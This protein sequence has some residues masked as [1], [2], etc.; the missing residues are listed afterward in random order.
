[1]QDVV[2]VGGGVIGLSIA[3]ELALN[4]H[5]V[6]VID[7]AE[8]GREASWA[9]AGILPPGYCGEPDD[10]LVELTAAT[11]KLWPA[12][13]ET[14]RAETGI[15]NGF[16]RSGSI[17]LMPDVSTV[18][19][20][21]HREK[22]TST[23][24]QEIAAWRSVG[25]EVEPLSPKQ[26]ARKEPA[27]SLNQAIGYRLP[28]LCQV[29]NPWHLKAIIKSCSQAGVRLLPH[30]PLRELERKANRITAAVV[31]G[32]RL[33][34]DQFVIAAG[35]WA[36]SLLESFKLLPPPDATGSGIPHIQPVRGQIVLLKLKKPPFRHV[37]ECGHRYLVPRDDG[38]VLIGATEE[39][40][41]FQK[42]N[43]D[44]AI[45]SLIQFAEELVPSLRGA[46]VEHTWS[47]L[48]PHAPHGRPYIGPIEGYANLA[49][50]AGHFRA[51][52]HLS[53]ITA[54]RISEL[55][56]RDRLF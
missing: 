36:G 20:I 41:G 5:K 31:D 48:R 37:I 39:W 52:L 21:T 8:M 1:M 29:R 25:V 47:G 10:P 46:L 24:E 11:H 33:T 49:L 4:G 38:R 22:V 14:L 12:L 23:R 13:S 53:P 45:S 6:T 50:A 18:S 15:D 26:I 43:T 16:R 51:G 19:E 28:E 40:V 3:R 42:G 7:R 30:H 56:K 34:A 27:I 54:Q 32:E 17:E 9:G 35:A 55:L 44:T 2:I